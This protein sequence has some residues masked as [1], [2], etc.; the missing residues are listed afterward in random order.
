MKEI[1][2]AKIYIEDLP[3]ETKEKLEEDISLY[4]KQIKEY[5]KSVGVPRPLPNH[6]VI[7]SLLDIEYV[8]LSREEEKKNF[9]ERPN[10][11]YVKFRVEEYGS[12]ESQLEY[13]Q[14]NGIEEWIKRNNIIKKKYPKPK[15]GK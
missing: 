15:K 1:N 8:V 2:K 12:I 5:Q 7:I 13:I 9:K 6:P 3:Y 4:K 11:D 10:K 14:E